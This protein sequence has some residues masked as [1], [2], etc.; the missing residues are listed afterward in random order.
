MDKQLVRNDS[1][2]NSILRKIDSEK[3]DGQRKEER[4][5]R[6]PKK[7]NKNFIPD[8][9]RLRGV[10]RTMG[11][12]EEEKIVGKNNE[13]YTKSQYEKMGI[14]VLG[15]YNP[16]FYSVE[17]PEGWEIRETESSMWSSLL[18]RK[19]RKR[20]SFFYK[21]APWDRDAFSKFACRYSFSIV[22]F[23]NFDTDVEYEERVFRPWKLFITD[24]GDRIKKLAEVAASTKEEYFAL[25][26]KFT[27][28]ARTFLN[29]NYP[30]WED[31]HAYW[32]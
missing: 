7:T 27:E 26:D 30:A 15:E 12:R 31:I 3:R 20:L 16:L 29:E 9:Y 10:T 24:S 13:D 17:L 22:P 1:G 18:D 8:D 5:S 28:M 14:K 11:W 6:L 4:N 19:G 2:K 25:N 21:S 23:D 32:D